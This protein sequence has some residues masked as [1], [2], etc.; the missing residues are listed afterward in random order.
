MA[1][2]R[3]LLLAAVLALTA[4]AGT[5]RSFEF[6]EA[7]LDAIHQGFKNGSLTSTALVQHYLSQISRLNPLLH[8]VIEVNP[9]ALRQAAQADAERRRS[10]SGDAKIAGG[11]HGVPVLLKDNIATRDGLNTTAGSLALLGSVVR[12]DAGVVARLRRAG[13]VVLGK[14]N[15]DEWA[16]FRSAIGTGGWSPRGGQ[17]K[18]PY[19]LSSPPCGSST[20]PAIAAAANMAAVTLGTE[21]D[22][23]I[24]CPSSLNSVV[25]IKPTVGLTSRAGVIPISPRQDTVG[26]IC[27]TVADAVHVLD[28]IV[29]YDELDAVATRAASKYI[30]DGGYTQFLKVD[31][32]EGKRIGVPNVFFD[33]PDGSV[34]QK[35]Y[36]QH[37]DTLR[38]GAVVIESLSIAN[39][40]VILNATVSGELVALAA[41]FKIV[42][43]AYLSS[44]LSR[45]PVA[46]LAEIIAFN[47]AH[48]DEEMLK[49]FG[50]L[51]FL[52]SQNTSGIGSVEKAAIQQL[53]ELTAN[54][55]EKT[56]RQHKLDAIVAPDSSLATVL[57]I[58]GLPGIAVPAGYDEQGAPFGITFGGLKGYEPRLIEIAYA[59]EQ[60]TKARKPPMFKN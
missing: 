42:L 29:G 2:L 47:N 24:L 15:M 44:D 25:G 5:S 26:P 45:S 56:M 39:L 27:R 1:W 34:R 40:D 7:T 46:S 37:L 23:S 6:E 19:V 59:F 38:N 60:A 55:V 18:N 54:G 20:G 36:H 53:D 33:F 9:D 13:A 52:V 41:E 12:R 4:G 49:Q 28:A 31:G 21:T 57:A 16:N 11:L 10:S 43:N 22:G 58:G 17:G 14:A 3:L 32:L 30:P 8:A 35:V 51:I 50:Q 48:P